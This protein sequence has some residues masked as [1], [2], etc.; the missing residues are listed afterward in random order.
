MSQIELNNLTKTYK[1]TTALKNIDLV[2]KD[3]EF[4]VLFG[5][6]GAGKTTMLKMIAGLEF[7]DE[8]LIKINDDIVNVVPPANR[9]VSMVFENYALYPHLSVYDNIASPMR[10]SLYREDEEYIKK[11]I[12]AVTKK[13]KIDNLLERL[14]SQLSNG[15]RQR[16]ALGRCLVR[17]PNVFLMDEP[18]AHLDAKLRHFMR[19]ELK[20]MQ[21]SFD[22]TTIYVTHDYMEALSLGDRIAIIN[23]GEIVQIGT[24][25]ELFYTPCNQFVAGLMG[26]P[27]INLIP[28]EIV[29][30]NGTVKVKLLH[31]DHLFEVPEDVTDFFRKNSIEGINLGVR[32]NDMSYSR[33]KDDDDFMKGSVYVLEPIGNRSILTAEVDGHKIRIIVPND[34]S[35][36]MD[37][38][39]YVKLDLKYSMFFDAA[40]EEFLIR[41]NQNDLLQDER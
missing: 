9:N 17:K 18:L 5:P 19:A 26:E 11:S 8:G 3:K 34:Y 6:A 33:K 22:T 40:T 25:N 39:I 1:Q 38:D 30:D 29:R 27:E 12:M 28:A 36:E 10:S 20:E 13:M 15:Q 35:C 23:L 14:P 7:P 32:G 31:Q 2:V 4:I 41:H 16:V 37:S 21:S 24:G